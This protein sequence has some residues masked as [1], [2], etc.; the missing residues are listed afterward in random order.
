[1]TPAPL[2]KQAVFGGADGIVLGIGFV[3]SY[4][5]QP[6]G[7]V[8]AALTA[9]LAELVGMTEGSWLSDSGAG[10]I[11]A[12]GNGSA[13]FAACFIP[14]VPYLFTTGA[15]AF[16]LAVLLVLAVAGIIAWLRPERGLLAGVQTFGTLVLAA[17]FC[18]AVSFI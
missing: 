10:F 18:W 1:V 4:A 13:A 14:A 16:I 12:L 2:R 9:G 8:K 5:T 15:A 17:L 7:I 11:P 3:A 6:H